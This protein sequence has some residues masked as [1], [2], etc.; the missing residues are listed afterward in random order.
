MNTL[1]VNELF[2][3]IQGEGPSVGTPSI[4]LRLTGC[5]LR[6]TFRDSS[7]AWTQGTLLSIE[8][9]TRKFSDAGFFN[10]LRNGSHLVLTGGDPLAQQ[11]GIGEL[12]AF[13]LACG[14]VTYKELFVE[15]E[16]QA[17]IPLTEPWTKDLVRQW[18]ISPKLASSG[19]SESRRLDWAELFY[20]R[21]VGTEAGAHFKFSVDTEEDLLEMD[22]IV[23]RLQLPGW[24]VWLMPVCDNAKDF[25]LKS[26]W[27]IPKCIRRG[28]MFS[29]RLQVAVYDR[30]TGV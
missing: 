4:F 9:L 20:Y 30:V 2:S 5:P 21:N 25:A 22:L 27:L 13:W 26:E 6:C 11:K 8:E 1:K 24:R 14:R 12:L 10:L 16:T 18:N 23:A 7:L 15:V 3:S 19:M 28:C 17:T 29:P